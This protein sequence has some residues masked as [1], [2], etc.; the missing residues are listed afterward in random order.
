M[1]RDLL[2]SMDITVSIMED[3]IG[4][5]VQVGQLDADR[6]TPRITHFPIS[7]ITDRLRVEFGPQAE[8]KGLSL[9]FC[10]PVFTVVSDRALLERILSNLVA[11]AIKYTEIGGTLVGLRRRGEKIH[12]EVWDSGVGIPA[13]QCEA[14]FEEFH[15]IEPPHGRRKEGLGLG[16]N[17]AHRLAELLGHQITLRSRPG[18]GS[19]FGIELPLGNVWQSELGE[20]EI[21][22]RIG[23]EF[24]DVRMLVVEDNDL[25]RTT[26]AEMLERWGVAVT[27]AGTGAQALAL[28]R[29]G[30]QPEIVLCDYRLP[31]G[32]TGQ[33]VLRQM[34]E[35]L[36]RNMPAIIAT[37]DTDPTLI[38]GIRSTGVP[39]LIKPINPARLRSAMHHLL[40][41]QDNEPL[42]DPAGSTLK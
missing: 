23:G 13:D 19:V 34:R 6:I 33:D 42:P 25:L 24:L 29:D 28:L 20:P 5:L 11:N 30:Y 22:E 38:A 41:E 35:I 9:R 27:V 4:T 2:H 17:I 31:N 8:A 12:V 37:A 15:Q 36:G 40:Y 10:G 3:I 21:S 26:V 16:L 39:V 32:E 14:I 18:R 1:R 7:Q